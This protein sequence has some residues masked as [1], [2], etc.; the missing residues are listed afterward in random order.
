[1][2]NDRFDAILIPK[3]LECAVSAGIDAGIRQQKH[4]RRR[5]VCYKMLAAAAVFA[6]CLGI[7][8]VSNP[9]LAADLP[10][11]GRIFAQMQEKVSYKGDFDSNV[12][13]LVDAETKEEETGTENGMAESPYRQTSNGLT[14]IV[15]ET[16]CSTQ[17]LYLALCIENEEDFPEGFMRSETEG[18]VLDYDVLGLESIDY[19]N[20]A[21][22]EKSKRGAANGVACPG[23]IEGEF[24]DA[25]TFAGI[26]RVPLDNLDLPEE[27]TYYLDISDVYGELPEYEE[28]T[29]LDPDGNEVTLKE[30][31]KKHYKGTW[32]F[33]IDFTMKG[34]GEQIIEV[35]QK[36]AEGIGVASVKKTAYEITAEVILPEGAPA[37]DYATVICDAD[38]QELEPQG[39]DSEVFSTYGRNTDTIYIYICDYVQ[40]MDE[41]KGSPQKLARDALFQ[42][43]VHF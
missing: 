23:Y 22:L 31:V 15:S 6:V 19:Y 1:M 39:T 32:N 37:Y 36:N 9:S 16:S 30:P 35:N 18:Y 13:V 26:I 24:T 41:L 25:R 20:V 14:I 11:I 4:L 40:Y 33:A 29:L 43:E 5:R 42:T 8:F 10:I 17:A 2:Q 34:E 7:L 28:Q 38:G 27:F 21:G 12:E 3:E